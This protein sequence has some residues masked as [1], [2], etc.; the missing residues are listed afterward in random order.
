MEFTEVYD[1][2]TAKLNKVNEI[3][4]AKLKTSIALLKTSI[5]LLFTSF[6]KSSKPREN[7]FNYYQARI[8]FHGSINMVVDFQ[9]R[10]IV[11]YK[12]VK[13]ASYQKLKSSI[14]S[15][16]SNVESTIL[17]LGSIL[18]LTQLLLHP[19]HSCPN[20]RR[21]GTKIGSGE[22]ELGR[23]QLD[24]LIINGISIVLK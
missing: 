19:L 21:G 12:I 2:S 7:L 24:E 9:T 14:I 4:H 5:A 8:F 20:C 3:E 10:P 16:Y 11:P 18:T 1:N 23:H 22:I 17:M 13:R 15:K 6:L